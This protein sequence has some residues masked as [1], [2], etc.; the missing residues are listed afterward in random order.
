MNGFRDLPAA[1]VLVG[2]RGL[3]LNLLAERQRVLVRRLGVDG[4]GEP[5]LLGFTE[6]VDQQVAS[7]GSNPGDEGTFGVVVA[8]KRA[9]HLD[10]DL[11]GEVFGVVG[12]SGETVADVIDT[13]VVG[14]D[15]FLP[16]SVVAG[17]AAA[18]QHRDYL[19]VFQ[20]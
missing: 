7:D 18:D 16:G 9:V 12:R 4:V 19:D 6:V 2:R 20:T 11:L 10:E 17:T 5:V 1:D 8:G 13:A 15:D 14:L 3:V